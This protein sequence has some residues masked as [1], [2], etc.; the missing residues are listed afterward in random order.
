[1]KAVNPHECTCSIGR[2]ASAGRCCGG[3]GLPMPCFPRWGPV[4]PEASRP[5]MHCDERGLCAMPFPKPSKIVASIGGATK[6]RINAEWRQLLTGGSECGGATWQIPS[7][8]CLA[9]ASIHAVHPY[10]GR[11]AH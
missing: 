3:H 9:H 1:M 2:T 4:T 7:R 10:E 8:S 11:G 5:L 6:P